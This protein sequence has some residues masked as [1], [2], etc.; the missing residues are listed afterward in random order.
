M[1]SILWG[2][3]LPPGLQAIPL[4]RMRRLEP[5]VQMRSARAQNWVV[6]RERG[7]LTYG[8]TVRTSAKGKAD[9]LFANGTKIAMRGGT[10]IQIVPP[11]N[12]NDPLVIRLFGALSEVFVRPKGN[13]QIRTAAAI[14][15]AR[16]TE[17]L[18]RLVD[19]NTT[20]VTVTEGS[21][22]FANAQGRVV[23]EA[24]Q[25]S[26]A[27]VG[28]AP[29]VPVAVDVSG[30]LRW[31]ADVTDLPLEW[32]TPFRSLDAA[33]AARELQLA[34][35][36]AVNAPQNI[37]AQQRLAEA[38]YDAFEYSNASVQFEKVAQMQPQNVAALVGL[39]RAQRARGDGAAALEASRRALQI[40]PDNQTAQLELALSQLVRGDNA[41][42]QAALSN[43]QTMPQAQAVLGLVALRQGDANRAETFFRAALAS[44]SQLSSVRSSSVRSLLALSLLTQNRVPEAEN[45][46]RL[47][48][49]VQ[50]FS[51]QNQGA[52]S[53]VL[54]F[55]GDLRGA[56]AAS[57][58]AV[59]AN[60]DSPFALL[61]Q[62]RVL[63]SQGRLDA[64]RDALA[65]AQALAPQLPIVASELGD[66]YLRLRQFPKAESNFRLAL[67]QSPALASAHSG[68]GAT[69]EAQGQNEQALAEL[70]RAVEL[71]PQDTSAR[72]RLVEFYIA[73]GELRQAEALVPNDL[74]PTPENGLLLARLSELSLFRQDL[75]KAQDY[76]RRAVSLLPNS[77]LAHYQLGRV[78]L[79]QNRTFQAEQQFRQ[80]AIL[81]RE[82]AAARFALGTIREQIESGRDLTRASSLLS[83]AN[84]GGAFRGLS[85][86]NLQA[87]GTED[88][89]QAALQD[90]TVARIATR[91]YGDTQID[92]MLGDKG[93]TN[94]SFS[95]LRQSRDQ[96][97]LLGV[98]ASTNSRNGARSNSDHTTDQIGLMLGQKARSNPSGLIFL[99]QFERVDQGLN[100]DASSSFA[101]DARV[102]INKPTILFGGN[103]QKS[104]DRR[105]RFL[106]QWTNFD[107]KVNG[108]ERRSSRQEDG[109]S[110]SFELRHDRQIGA[111]NYLSAG[112]GLGRARRDGDFFFGAFP[113]F[114]PNQRF[115]IETRI[116]SAEAYVRNDFSPNK[117]LTLT[118]E[119]QL[120]HLKS[121]SA[122]QFT[123][124]VVIPRLANEFVNRVFVLPKFVL[125]YRLDVNTGI[126]LRARRVLGAVTDFE[127]LRPTDLF[128]ALPNGLPLLGIGGRGNS[129]E[130]EA[131]HTFSD[132][133]FLRINLFAQ[134]LS[135]VQEPSADVSA[136]QLVRRARLRGL[137][138]SYEGSLG[139][140]TTFYLNAT[141]ND[142]EDEGRQQTIAF[143]PRF[144]GEAG[145]QYLRRDGWFAQPSYVYQSAR[146][147]PLAFGVERGTGAGF[148]L[149]NLRI[150]KRSGLRSAFYAEVVNIS[151]QKFDILGVQQPGR[152]FRIGAS[153]RF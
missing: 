21:V 108:F 81:D 150:G 23:V 107:D 85:L 110:Y 139:R 77:S 146:F 95:S 102:R 147:M 127:L 148:G 138:A 2:A 143:V 63:V 53:L 72:T 103:L 87:P 73:R 89:I 93:R 60:P 12:P 27:R 84:L 50:P 119:V 19:E 30:A 34:Q 122:I 43:L 66:V 47:A 100:T 24:N 75:L 79:E 57:R 17:Y 86:Q 42:A 131:D 55:R 32:E 136:G 152:Q 76:A 120:R 45:Q 4:A 65:R 64:A 94:A 54:F 135:D 29:T 56:Q 18:V 134:R 96:R 111:K 38:F 116:R 141:L 49:S 113:P 26:V 88:R 124:P 145:L 31:T 10:S 22:D 114:V 149:L 16:G 36:A 90:P 98:T 132:S 58:L 115:A 118:G 130:L 117:R 46:A 128:T 83:E 126:R 123:E 133:S 109:Q 142:A 105:T 1:L 92:G 40:D 78:Y 6:A 48:V 91:S 106:V 44:S 70:Q 35:R 62:G 101:R 13:T 5:V 51:A 25:Q 15:A 99:G 14:A 104:Q 11:A 137:S 8:D 74:A 37:E 41:A 67:A 52:L 28:Q 153:L 71:N 68:L 20:E 7:A 140:E 33:G 61:T 39:S 121:D 151:N 129:I 125:D 3:L 144:V 80:A 69:L 59:Q 97:G 112:L 9:V 82:N